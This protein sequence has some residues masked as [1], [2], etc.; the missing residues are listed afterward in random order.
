MTNTPFSKTRIDQLLREMEIDDLNKA[1]IRQ[2]G[3]IARTME[4]E[5]GQEYVHFEMGIPG[6]P[7]SAVGVEA[8]IAALRRGVA[9]KYPNIEGID[10][11]KTEASRFVKA[12]IDTDIAP[13]GCIPTTGSMQGVFAAFMLC[14]QLNPQRDTI[15]YIDPGFPVQKMQAAVIGARMASFDVAD[16]RGAAALRT[17]LE[18]VLSSG[19]VCCLIYSNPNNPSWM[20]LKDDELQVIGELATKYDVVVIED[21]AYMTM[22]FRRPLGRPFQA[23][24][25]PTV[26]R[27]TDNYV[28]MLSG[29]KMFSYAGQRIAVACISDRLF[30]RS[31][32]TLAARYGIS[33]FGAVYAYN[34]L[35][36]LSSGVSHSAQCAMAAMMHAATEGAYSFVDDVREYARRTARIKQIMLPY[37]FSVVYDRDQDEPVSDGLFFTIGYHDM[38]GGKLLRELLYYG[39][40]GIVLSTT[41]STRQGI[42]ACCSTMQEHHYQL[43]AERCRLFAE[44]H[45]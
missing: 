8:E 1:S 34:M 12:F 38:E 4:Q 5:T 16:Y 25:Q 27:Y 15:L 19:R 43:L 7:P 31:Y 39:I 22:D 41:G 26:S 42:R 17:K 21:L 35:Y 6:L 30:A 37:G 32:P 33:R 24:F 11:L 9:S 23:P 2:I 20:C 10:E 14:T 3:A 44:N 13:K 36:T 29:S 18:E 28:L 40:T 45:A